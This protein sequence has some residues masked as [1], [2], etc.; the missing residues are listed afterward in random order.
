[1]YRRLATILMIWVFIIASALAQWTEPVRIG[2]PGAYHYPQILAHGDTLHVVGTLLPGGDKIVYLRSDDAGNTWANSHVLSDTVN[3]TNAMFVRIVKHGQQIMVFWRSIMNSG[4][5]PWNIGYAL[6]QNN[7]D[8]W[9]GP[10]YVLNPGWDHILYFSASNSGA[11]VNIIVSRHIGYD[12]YFYGIRSTNFGQSW[13]Q[14]VELFSAAQSSTPDATSYGDI[15]HF[16]WAGRFDLENK[17]EVYY[18]RSTEGGINW[19]DNVNISEIDQ[20]HSYWPSISV[21]ETGNV[22][23]S[24]MDF[25]YSPNIFAGDIF[26]RGSYNSGQDW[27]AERQATFNHLANL[28]DIVTEMDTIHMAREDRR[29]EN[30]RRSIYY[31]QSTD[32]GVSWSDQYWLDR[33][34]SE[35][36][37]PAI[38]ASNGKVYVIWSDDRCDP[39]TDI[40]G[41]VYFTRL[42]NE[43]GIQVEEGTILPDEPSLDVYPNPFNS[44]CVIIISDPEIGFLEIYDIG[45]RQV[46]LLPV[47]DGQVV[48]EPINNS[49]GIY[50]A[51]A[52]GGDSN[53]VIKLLYLK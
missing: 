28:S 21:N 13:S 43:V 9:I 10:L 48:W 25:K 46:E 1:V 15:V 53:A 8:T 2:I 16:V 32:F 27:F 52:K 3:S 7:G 29:S 24:W 40:C 33:D 34:S 51:R 37:Q 20:H 18:I 50:F 36:R 47:S 12:L 5:R 22:A 41:G 11:V 35:S 6:S 39:D 26:L 17:Y 19:T 31:M 44:S 42:D 45:G 38:A 23:L 4:P 49:S 30:G 14:P